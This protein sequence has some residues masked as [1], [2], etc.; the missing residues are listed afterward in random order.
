[1]KQTKKTT[2]FKPYKNIIT[3]FISP[4]FNLKK[5]LMVKV[6]FTFRNRTVHFSFIIYI[7]L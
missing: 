4:I 3:K 2:N 7:R 5:I 1:M 6:S